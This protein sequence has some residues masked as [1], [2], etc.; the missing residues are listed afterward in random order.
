MPAIKLLRRREVEENCS[1]IKA[2]RPGPE[3]AAGLCTEGLEESAGES[4]SQ[5]CGEAAGRGRE[6]GKMGL[7]LRRRQGRGRR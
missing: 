1:K 4:G 2:I 3:G 6:S 7:Y 5:A